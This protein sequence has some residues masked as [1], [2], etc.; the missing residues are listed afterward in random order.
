RGADRLGETVVD[1]IFGNFCA[2]K[3]KELLA[4]FSGEFHAESPFCVIFLPPGEVA[5]L[6]LLG[7]GP[8][9][10][11]YHATRGFPRCPAA[12][13]AGGRALPLHGILSAS[14][15]TFRPGCGKLNN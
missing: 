10:Q 4:Q 14:A 9:Y 8:S 6:L 12:P 7:F 3:F 11:S 5:R 13:C 2:L 15:P 1:V